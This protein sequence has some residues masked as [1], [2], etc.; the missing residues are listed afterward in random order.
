MT[1]KQKDRAYRRGRRRNISVRSV[2][3]ATPDLQKMTRAVIQMALEQA[4][5]E[6]AAQDAVNNQP[7]AR[8]N[9]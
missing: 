1:D 3:R 6:K 4:A 5:A 7:E 9:A 8:P 2:R